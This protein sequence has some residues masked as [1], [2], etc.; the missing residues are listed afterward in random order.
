MLELSQVCHGLVGLPV[1]WFIGVIMPD[2]QL[3]YKSPTKDYVG[4]DPNYI[5][6]VGFM[7]VNTF[8]KF[9][10]GN[11]EYTKTMPTQPSVG[12]VF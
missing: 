7:F 2:R 8:L 9:F 11:A 3:L 5:L 6:Q 12:I 4:N 1:W 10:V